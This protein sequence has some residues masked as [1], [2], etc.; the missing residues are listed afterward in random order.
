[1]R[2]R[3]IPRRPALLLALALALLLASACAPKVVP[4]PPAGRDL[5]KGKP[6]TVLGHTYQP[7]LA[8]HGYEERG[9]ASWYG[10]T[11]HGRLTSNGEVYDM[12][13]MTAAHKLLPLG[14]WVE[15][16]NLNNNKK[17]VVRINDRG[18]FVDGRIIDLS[19]A[20]AAKLDVIGP[21]TAPVMV[22]A[23]GSR[24][25]GASPPPA[26]APTAVVKLGPFAVQV[27]A[28]GS[29]SNAWRLAAVL[30]PTFK[31][32]SVVDY[33]RGD[34]VFKRVWVGKLDNLD[35]AQK[36][37]D[38]LRRIGYKQAFVVAW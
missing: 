13:K 6:Y 2:P 25:P 1:M 31:Q 8:A 30:R 32:V 24:P 36:L 9:L 20:A 12:H 14:T 26:S 23:L 4:P 35:E 28:F 19:K 34:M 22:R 38:R 5:P 18:P 21:G 33:N 17:A 15:V 29:E 7:Y 10:P 3:P 16:T 11:F 27:G 37:Q